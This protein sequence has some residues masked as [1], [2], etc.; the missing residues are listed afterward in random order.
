[1]TSVISV[2]NAEELMNALA[3]VKGGDSIVLAPGD[4]GDLKMGPFDALSGQFA[5]NVT[6]TSADPTMPASFS[7]LKLTNA[8]NITFDNVVF[9]HKYS[10]GDSIWEQP[11]GMSDSTNITITNSTFDGDVPT[12]VSSVD[13]G[14]G[15]GYGLFVR[16]SS[17]IKLDSNEFHTFRIG[18]T[19][20]ETT[21]I[22]ITN[23]NIHSMRSDGMNMLEVQNVLI[24]DNYLHDFE[25][26]IGSGDH[27]DMI[28]FWTGYTDAPSTDIIIR[29]NLLD[30]G[31]GDWTQSI[32]MRNDL[33][34]QGLAGSEMFYQ[35]IL[36]ENNTIYNGHLHGITIGETNGLVI[37]NNSVIQA[38]GRDGLQEGG[39]G[40][41]VINLADSSTNV[42]VVSNIAGGLM[43][44][45]DQN[46]WS[47]QNNAFIQNDD[48]NAPGYYDDVFFKSSMSPREGVHEFV[49]IPGSM[50]DALG[51]GSTHVQLDTQPDT[52]NPLFNVTSLENGGGAIVFDASETYGPVDLVDATIEWNFGDGIVATG[53]VV[54]HVFGAAGIYEVTAT[55]RLPDGTAA[56]TK[57]PVAIAGD[58]I[59]SFDRQ[60]GQFINHAYGFDE[61]A[62]GSVDDLV[63]TAE[64]YGIQMGGTGFHAIIDSDDIARI[65][66]ADNFEMSMTISADAPGASSGEILRLHQSFITEVDQNGEL[67]FRLF[68]DDGSQVRVRTQ[69]VKLDD[70]Q[71]HQ[72][73]IA[74]NGAEDSL[75]IWIDEALIASEAV[76]GSLPEAKRTLTFGNGW[77]QDNFDGKLL[78]FSLS[79]ASNDFSL[80]DGATVPLSSAE[81]N[82]PEP[83]STPQ[84]D[85]VLDS[86]ETAISEPIEPGDTTNSPES[87][88]AV[89][90]P[91]KEPD[92]EEE[93]SLPEPFLNGGYHLDFASKKI[94]F[95]DDAHL[96]DTQDGTAISFDGAKDFV[97]LGRLKEFETSQK[98]AFSVDF[99]SDN[100]NGVERLVWN[101][102]KVGLALTKDGLRVHVG[103][104]E[105]TFGKYFQVD[106]FDLHDGSQHNVTVMV[107]AET[108]RLQVLV[109]NALV[110]DEQ[111]TDFELV[112]AGG[113]EWGWSLG[114]AWDSWF[115]GEVYD[116]QVSDQFAFAETPLITDGLNF[117]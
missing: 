117:A 67:F 28:Q 26:A 43:G 23:N 45:G 51:A 58:N 20:A 108:D 27:R 10:A 74:F 87:D 82:A 114:T 65:F 89:T 85:P 12:G 37:R 96:V 49:V 69:G 61:I 88:P 6:I 115:D 14:V 81:I 91:V 52:V 113:H 84:E 33:V 1:M 62:A 98:L 57:A 72:I 55:V 64:G 59:V 36:I 90:E 97:S 48:P 24:E 68:T 107:D 39:I 44:F 103:N 35:N 93:S 13:D 42:Q 2:S 116:L 110:L 15:T 34:D 112:G 95:R 17:N 99:T 16:G 7:G 32:F 111:E 9:D 100:N 83:D 46:D 63:T 77:G 19:F 60:S 105:D 56:S 30:I 106:E 47:R 73:R 3:L 25:G 38:E 4:Y 86:S 80:Y 54:Q 70:G 104:S 102:M 53:A 76:T 8:S 11:F 21:G 41:P 5:S 79:S 31:E 75:Q 50:I 78:D 92:A 94:K 18:I 71:A 22:E 109:D 66:G 40:V 29:G 101:H